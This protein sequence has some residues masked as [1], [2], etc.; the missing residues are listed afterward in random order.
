VLAASE[1]LAAE[2]EADAEAGGESFQPTR[3]DVPSE[4]A[5]RTG[6][7]TKLPALPEPPPPPKRLPLAYLGIGAVVVIGGIA[8]VLGLRSSRPAPP[9]AP[10]AAMVQV[11]SEPS[12]AAVYVDGRREGVTPARLPMPRQRVT[13][14]RLELDGFQPFEEKFTLGKDETGRLVKAA[15]VAAKPAGG[16]IVVKTNVKKATWK[17]DGKPVGDGTG[18]LSLADVVPG[19]HQLSVES[20]GFEGR[21]EAVDVAPKGLASVVWD[22]KPVAAAGPKKPRGPK[23]PGKAGGRDIDDIGGWPP[24]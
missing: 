15:L 14:L 21:A 1:A 7:S 2:A 5:K 6:Q 12:G 17:L 3:A 13:R 16:R 24:R 18:H 10:T 11:E 9:S 22:L 20:E 4:I 19:S 23:T 8:L